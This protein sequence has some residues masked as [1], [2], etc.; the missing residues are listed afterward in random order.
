MA[1]NIQ[2][3][4]GYGAGSADVVNSTET[5]NAYAKVTALSGNS[6]TVDNAENF[7]VGGEIFLHDT[8][9]GRWLIASI[10]AKAA[11]VLTLNKELLWATLPAYLQAVSV[12]HF[13]T[14]T[15]ESG[16]SISPPAFQ[17]GK[18]GIVVF[19]CSESLTLGGSIDLVDKGIAVADKS[20][21]PYAPHEDLAVEDTST[22]SGY[23]NA[24]MPYYVPLNVGDG[25]AF[26][27]T[28]K[29]IKTNSGRLGNPNTGGYAYCRGANHPNRPN[30]TNVGGSTILLVAET[31]QGYSPLMLSKYRDKNKAEGKGLAR[32]YVAS[33]TVLNND[34]ALYSYDII[35]D[36]TRLKTN[37]NIS[38]FG[39]GKS[40][41]RTNPTKDVNIFA[42]VVSIDDKT[43]AYADK[44]ADYTFPQGALVMIHFKNTGSTYTVDSGR[45]WLSKILSDDGN[46]LTLK[47]APPS[48]SLKNY[49]AQIVHIPRCPSFTLNQTYDFT[50]KYDGKTGGIFAIAVKGVC[51]LRGGVINMERKGD[52]YSSP[53]GRINEPYN[54][55][56]KPMTFGNVYSHSRLP[57]GEGHGSIFILAKTLKLDQFSRLGASYPGNAFGGANYY[58]H[59]GGWSGI[60]D[61]GEGLAGS[62]KSGGHSGDNY[63]GYGCASY[64]YDSNGSR[65]LDAPQGAH[66]FIV[67]DTIDGLNLAAISTGGEGNSSGSHGG[68]GYGGGSNSGSGG[69]LGGGANSGVDYLTGWGGGGG[70]GSAFIYCNNVLNQDTSSLI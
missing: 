62:G 61:D 30:H 67:A 16:H 59:R 26:I 69:Y 9:P 12:P 70:A 52:Y 13:K 18:G 17:N 57:L 65:W 33:N 43:I 2:A 10:T 68:A 21:R 20:I 64:H 39:D 53:V 1:F 51:D 35:S 29:L 22:Y 55:N 34:E 4:Q 49:S 45:F 32:C 6:I 14:L 41:A 58:E 5:I 15:I 25:L 27:L 28:K 3:A 24:T 54:I 44:S 7:N 23:E 38:N 48:I 31:I 36:P 37:C 56:N 50:K 40:S 19:K 42:R 8:C 66:I 60:S 46:R 63:G 11:N 47:D